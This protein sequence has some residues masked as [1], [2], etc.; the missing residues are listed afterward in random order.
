M[1]QSIDFDS[2]ITNFDPPD[3]VYY[4]IYNPET[5]L[6]TGIYPEGVALDQPYKIK[7]D[8]ILAEEINDGKIPLLNC[9][10][11]LETEEIILDSKNPSQNENQSLYL[12]R[13]IAENLN[14]PTLTCKF[15]K[16]NS[17]LEIILSE[18]LMNNKSKYDF[19]ENFYF[20]ITSKN[21]PNILFQSIKIS[22]E[23]LFS[24]KFS[25]KIDIDIDF[26]IFTKK[27]FKNYY[28]LIK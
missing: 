25:K 20:Y 9:F 13:S 12:I 23:E 11:D 24:N 21:D 18:S 17:I 8:R 26:S 6:V 22:Q 4:A 28:F 2:W 19:M 5:L 14:L 7:I 15:E 27:I 16:E 3:I 10:V 1:N